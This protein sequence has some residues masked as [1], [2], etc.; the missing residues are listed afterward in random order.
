MSKTRHLAVDIGASSGKSLLGTWDGEDLTVEETHRFANTSSFVDGHLRWD[1]DHLD[2]EIDTCQ[3]KAG[4]VDTFGI[5]TWGVDFALL[6]SSDGLLG[7]PVH[8]RDHR[9]DG[10]LA[11]LHQLIPAEKLYAATGIQE[12]QINTLVQL[13]ALSRQEPDVLARARTFLTIPDYLHWR[14]TGVKACEFTNATTT[15]CYDPVAGSWSSEL[16]S[17]VGVDASVFPAVAQPGSSPLAGFVLP[18]CHDTGSA[19][20]ALDLEDG[21]YWISSGTWS[22]VG[23]NVPRPILSEAAR[24]LNLTN[25]GGLH[26]TFR[27]GK[28]VMGLWILQEWLRHRPEPLSHLLDRVNKTQPFQGFVNVDSPDLLAPDDMPAVLQRMLP[29]LDGEA[30]LRSVMESLAVKYRW[31]VAALAQASGI[32]CRRVRIIGGGCQNA[33]LN[34]MTADCLGVPVVAGPV[35]ATALG[36]LAV[37]IGRQ[38]PGAVRHVQRAIARMTEPQVFEPHPD[39]RWDATY[40]RLL[41]PV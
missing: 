36:N 22:I 29:G 11:E 28:N 30:I 27:L 24:L 18:A 34:Q 2:A 12:M 41:Q 23:V 38:D 20:A 8:Y 26:G 1:I 4:P 33:L 10:M 6:D 14:R 39:D 31:V 40:E 15:Q 7:R 5:D 9:T 19:V 16:M 3:R 32:P 13:L 17:A 25:E 35:E 37:Q 21:D